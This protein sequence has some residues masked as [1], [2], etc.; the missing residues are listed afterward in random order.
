MLHVMADGVE[1][2]RSVGKEC[3]NS[4]DHYCFEVASRNSVTTR[5]ALGVTV[6]NAVDT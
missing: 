3:A 5:T 6:T 2:L 1:D 4:V